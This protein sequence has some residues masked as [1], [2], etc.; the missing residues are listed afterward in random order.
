MMTRPLVSWIMPSSSSSS[1]SE[2]DDDD[3]EEVE[4]DDEN[5]SA[6][7]SM[8]TPAQSLS[9][10]FTE[11][12]CSSKRRRIDNVTLA[13]PR[14]DQKK[15]SPARVLIIPQQKRINWSQADE[16]RLLRTFL[17]YTSKSKTGDRQQRTDI[18]SSV[19]CFYDQ[20]EPELK[21]RFNRSQLVDKLKRLKRKYLQN[22]AAAAG[23]SNDFRFKSPHD[24]AAFE[25]SHR[26][27]SS[28]RGGDREE[29]SDRSELYGNMI[30]KVKREAEDSIDDRRPRTRSRCAGAGL[31]RSKGV[32]EEEGSP[33]LNRKAVSDDGVIT[34][35]GQAAVDEKWKKQ[36]IMELEVYSKRLE[37]VQEHV[38]TTL[39][40]LRSMGQTTPS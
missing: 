36:Q 24:E 3:D 25:V 16:L 6:S 29:E 17:D 1:S 21:L 9:T 13:L 38:K 34:G 19:Y 33:P 11:E 32:A 26:I 23:N 28:S 15:Q 2:Y 7:P 35:G 30:V 14:V 5:D 18:S 12:A 20:V 8:E 37:L 22:V 4:T 39:E 40:R 10:A 31:V 27:W